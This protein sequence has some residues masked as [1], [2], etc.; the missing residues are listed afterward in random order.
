MRKDYEKLFSNLQEIR[1]DE[2]L[3]NVILAKIEFKT[4][5]I[6]R[7]K[8]ALLCLVAAVSLVATVPAFQYTYQEFQRSG[9]FQYLSLLFSDSSV[10]LSY[11]YAFALSLLESLPFLAIAALL[12]SVFIFLEALRFAAKNIRN[13]GPLFIK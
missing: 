8:F 6:A 1:P 3:F 10:V 13:I 7:L 4:I 12:G 2:R 5:M 9:F 11:W